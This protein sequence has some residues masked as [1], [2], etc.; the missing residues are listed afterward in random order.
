MDYSKLMGPR[1]KKLYLLAVGIQAL[2]FY[3]AWAGY[4]EPRQDYY[5]SW[6][7]PNWLQGPASHAIFYCFL[8]AATIVV[9]TIKETLK[10]IWA[11]RNRK[12]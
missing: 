8:P 7:G 6:S 4:R 9:M 10:D 1:Q 3:L 2:G 12:D 11:T 5:K